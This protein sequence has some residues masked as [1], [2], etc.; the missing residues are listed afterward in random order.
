MAAANIG[1]TI[2]LSANGLLANDRVVFTTI[3]DSGNV[4]DWVAI[5]AVGADGGG[6]AG[7]AGA[8]VDEAA[9]QVARSLPRARVGVVL[10]KPAEARGVGLHPIVNRTQQAK[11]RFRLYR[12]LQQRRIG[13][14][15]HV[16][17]LGAAHRQSLL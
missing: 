1:Q 15:V 16:E 10:D 12:A 7:T 5:Y 3:N 9:Q 2:T 6:G 14:N 13:G 8:V 17:L 11:L 4:G